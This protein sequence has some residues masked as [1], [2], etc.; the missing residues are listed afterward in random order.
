MN[1]LQ[2][3]VRERYFYQR[4]F[5][6][7][8]AIA[9]QNVIIFSVNL[10]DNIMLGAFQETSLSGVAL[11]NQIQ[12]L[13]QM[14]IMG[15]GEGMIILASRHWGRRET[16]PIGEIISVGL[17]LAIGVGFSMWA[18]TFFFPHWC[19]SLFTKDEAVIAEGVKY[20]RIIC[21]SYLF[22]SMTN[23]LLAILRSVETVRIA[24][25]VSFSTLVVNVCLNYVLIF[26]NFGAPRLGARGA[27]IATLTARII[28]F[29]IVCIYLK[30]CDRKLLLKMKAFLQFNKAVFRRFLSVG[31]PV[32]LANAQWGVAMGIQTGILG[33]MGG[34]AIAANSIAT[35]VFQILTV[36]TYGSASASSVLIGKTI[37]EGR[38]DQM[39]HYAKTMQA[40]YL[41]IGAVTGIALFFAKDFIISFYAVS[42]STKALA[43]Q[44]MTV[45]SITVVGTAYQMPCL[46]GIVRGG[47]DTSFVLYNDLIFMWMIVLPASALS[48][49]VFHFSPVTVFICLKMDQILKCFVAVVR[50][51]R[52]RWLQYID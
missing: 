49:F 35:T 45:L 22:F 31:I 44:F 42:E 12:F 29:A 18:V 51:N 23:A 4:F 8:G 20:L 17:R 28:E 30:C 19:L 7:T 6:L 39:K 34:D 10:A 38:L 36:I 50:V 16:E 1:V 40:L 41:A 15:I 27:A 3:F 52:Y 33:H 25:L 13:L 24:F 47:G 48:A 43:L 21:F 26:G 11:V 37:G 9:L 46:T 32:I 2:L 5:A 14:L